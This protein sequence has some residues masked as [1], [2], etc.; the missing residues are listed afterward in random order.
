MIYI[1][2]VLPLIS[3]FLIF[4]F[5]RIKENISW[6]IATLCSFILLIFSFLTIFSNKVLV[7]TV[8]GWKIPFGICL[9]VDKFSSLFLIVINLITFLSLIYSFSYMKKYDRLYF[10]YILF[11]LLLAGLNGVVITG[12]LF[13]FFVFLEIASIS[14]YALVAYK[15]GKEE[16]EASF[17][18]L[19]LGSIGSSFILFGIAFIYGRLSTLNMADISNSLEFNYNK[20][21]IIFALS[22]F[23]AGLSIK[24]ALVPFHAWLAD[25]HPAAPSPISSM[26]SGVVIKV[27]GVYGL[28]RLIFNIFGFNYNL[29]LILIFLGTLSMVVGVLLAIGQ[30]DFKRLLAYH[31]ISQIGYVVLGLGIGTPMGIVGGLFHLF[32]H[33]IFKSLLF[34]N[35]GAIEYNIKT[36]NLKEMGDLSKVMPI[37]SNSSLIASLSIAGIPPFCGFWSKLFIILAA[38]MANLKLAGFLCILVSLITLASFLKV[39]KYAFLDKTNKN[40]QDIKEVPF[41]MV[42]SMS[43]LAI[44]CILVGLFFPLVKDYIIEPASNVLINGKDYFKVILN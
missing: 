13:N 12:D 38:F 44:L 36:K 28:S 37:T 9:V 33:S 8:G 29:S 6:I 21:S 3:A 22:L 30:W 18:Y 35:A 1:F 15:G 14:S 17:K 5:G 7:Y 43:F 16:L 20:S 4:I 40:F 24:T 10:Y 26:L 32:N 23:I 31:S 41:S 19:I 27:L 11:C 42:F 25:A 39:Q 2:S 34:L